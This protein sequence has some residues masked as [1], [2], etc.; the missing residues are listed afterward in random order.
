[1]RTP[2]RFAMRFADLPTFAPPVANVAAL[3]LA[4]GFASGALLW[5]AED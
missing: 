2:V 1:M 3:V 4:A 5:P